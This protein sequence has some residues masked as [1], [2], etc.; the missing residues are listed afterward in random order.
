M[1]PLLLQSWR[2]AKHPTVVLNLAVK[3]SWPDIQVRAAILVSQA[4][5]EQG[6]STKF[7]GKMHIDCALP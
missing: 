1:L 7:R 3:Q 5:F 6:A 2:V 4:A